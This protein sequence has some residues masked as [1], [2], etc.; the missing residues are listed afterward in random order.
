[1][2][3]LTAWLG[4]LD[5]NL[6]KVLTVVFI[7]LIPLYPKFPLKMFND[8]YIAIRLEDVFMALFCLAFAVQVVRRKVELRLWLL[9]LFVSYW[10]IGFVSFLYGAYVIPDN[11]IFPYE[12]FLHAARRIEYMIIFFIAASTVRS[13]EDLYFYI[14]CVAGAAFLVFMYGLGQKF[15]GWPAVQTMNPVFATG[16]KLQLTAEAR[17][18]STFAGHYDLAAY[19]VLL[20]PVL[21][22]YH[23]QRRNHW[24]FAVLLF[25]VLTLVMTSS[26]SSYGAY[27]LSM[28]AF[29]L[30]MRSWKYF[31]I[32][33][34]FTVAFT[35]SNDSLITRFAN[36]VRP[37][38]VFVDTN[39]G[40]T[41]QPE[42][43]NAANLPGSTLELGKANG[44]SEDEKRKAEE[45][46]KRRIEAEIKAAAAKQGDKLSQD[47]LQARVDE[48]FGDF[49]LRASNVADV[50]TAVRFQEEWPRAVRAFIRNPLLGTGPSS[51]T[52]SSDS[53]FFRALGEYGLLGMSFFV[54]IFAAI[55]M[56]VWK[57]ARAMEHEH[58]PLFYGFIFG[59]FGLIINAT[60]IDVFEASKVAYT[61]WLLAGITVGAIRYFVPGMST[62]PKTEEKNRT[63]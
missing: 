26:R 16:L 18:S 50:S 30:F 29:L 23:M 9:P 61:L 25:A 33:L 21:V 15:L 52:E 40:G 27:I 14:K 12:G 55:M 59:L 2:Q 7:F 57:A 6:L 13:R 62:R 51:I 32:V 42:A 5:K 41:V 47:E 8:T 36:T 3:K 17:V 19:V 53:S 39:T 34:I 49:T 60:Y 4:W 37:K 28:F 44:L 31:V 11:I 20:A 38:A 43:P 10:A 63:K 22:A 46:L 48:R 24:V 58:R 56:A 45:E 35:L 54:A 1:M